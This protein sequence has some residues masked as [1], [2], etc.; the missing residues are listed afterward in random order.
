MQW[1]IPSYRLIFGLKVANHERIRLRNVSQQSD[2]DVNYTDL[3]SPFCVAESG[4]RCRDARADQLGMRDFGHQ[5]N[6]RV[7]GIINLSHGLNHFAVSQ[8]LIPAQMNSALF[9]ASR[10]LR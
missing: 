6:L 4:A 10:L 7:T 3:Y 5:C 1:D 8:R 9:I 2:V